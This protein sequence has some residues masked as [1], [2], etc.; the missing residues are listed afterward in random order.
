MLDSHRGHVGVGGSEQVGRAGA[1]LDVIREASRVDLRAFS[2]S[3]SSWQLKM[4]S[5]K[6]KTSRRKTK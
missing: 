4:D 2:S 6:N 3:P 5:E 1:H